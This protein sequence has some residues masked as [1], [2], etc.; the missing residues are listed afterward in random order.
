[1]GWWT[2]RHTSLGTSLCEISISGR[3]ASPLSCII[4]AVVP[5]CDRDELIRYAE[6]SPAYLS[7][8]H[9]AIVVCTLRWLVLYSVRFKRIPVDVVVGTLIC[10][11]QCRAGL[12][13]TE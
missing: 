1:M 6:D 2:G 7:P 13:G 3:P 10:I 11:R 4:Q 5:F 9:V 12:R 8:V